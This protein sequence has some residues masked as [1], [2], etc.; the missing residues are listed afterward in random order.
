MSL[1]DKQEVHVQDI[2]GHTTMRA[3]NLADLYVN[4]RQKLQHYRARSTEERSRIR[5]RKKR[6]RMPNLELL[7][8]AVRT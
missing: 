6:R 7:L 1:L 8:R 5:R 3:K 2:C 4:E